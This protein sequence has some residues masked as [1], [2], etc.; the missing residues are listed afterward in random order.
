MYCLIYTLEEYQGKLTCIISSWLSLTLF[1]VCVCVWRGGYMSCVISMGYWL[2]RVVLDNTLCIRCIY[3]HLCTFD[4]SNPQERKAWRGK[5]YQSYEYH[6][7]HDIDH[8]IVQPAL[9]PSTLNMADWAVELH[10]QVWGH[11]PRCCIWWA[12]SEKV[13]LWQYLTLLMPKLTVDNI[14]LFLL[15]NRF[16]QTSIVLC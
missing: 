2:G 15:D 13:L 12:E 7:E 8:I 14:S 6:M 5:K 11:R 10:L 4:N 9:T 1:C 16:K 3:F